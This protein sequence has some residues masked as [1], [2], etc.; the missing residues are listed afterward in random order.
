MSATD[1][2]L[3][4]RVRDVEKPVMDIR[5][6]LRWIK[7]VVMVGI[8]MLVIQLFAVMLQLVGGA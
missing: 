5:A 3:E 7:W 8:P 4:T 2:G 6:D 1:V